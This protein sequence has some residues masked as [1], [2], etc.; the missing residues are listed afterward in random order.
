MRKWKDLH[1]VGHGR[2]GGDHAL[3][4]GNRVENLEVAVEILVELENGGDVAAPVAV[5]G[6]RPHRDEVLLGEH[7]LVSL[8]HE[9][10]RSADELEAVDSRKL[11][12]F[13]HTT[14]PQAT[15]HAREE[16]RCW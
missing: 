8:L 12:R 1:K 15:T 5:V 14:R 11:S 3:I 10:V 7:V 2:A 13:H 4:V 16:S 6:G 9:L